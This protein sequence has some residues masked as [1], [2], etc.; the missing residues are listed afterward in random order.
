MRIYLGKE[1]MIHEVTVL[2][3]GMFI[4]DPELEFFSI[5]NRKISIPNSK[6]SNSNPHFFH[7]GFRIRIQEFKYFNPKNGFQALGNTIRVVFPGSGS[8]GH[9]GTGSR[10]HNTAWDTTNDTRGG[11]V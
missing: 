6:F 10:I 8:R 7:S 2:Q 3:I 9:K 11:T 5:Q 4:P 1:R